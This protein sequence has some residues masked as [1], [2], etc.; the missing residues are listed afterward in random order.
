M[1][2]NFVD[3]ILENA[4]I[5]AKHK[6]S[7]FLGVSDIKFAMEKNF[8]ISIPTKSNDNYK[9]KSNEIKNYSTIDHKKRVELTREECKNIN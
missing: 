7:D 5:F 9:L 1:G 3:N 4:C 2:D 6:Q 8:D